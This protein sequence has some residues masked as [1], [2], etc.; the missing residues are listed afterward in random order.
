[1]QASLSGKLTVE[2]SAGGLSLARKTVTV[3]ASYLDRLALGGAVIVALLVMLVFIV[4]RTRAAE[5]AGGDSDRRAG[6]TGE[7]DSEARPSSR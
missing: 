6:Y 5:R 2:V 7:D 4:R 3:R 1:M